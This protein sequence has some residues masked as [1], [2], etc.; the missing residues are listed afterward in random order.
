MNAAASVLT[1][2]GNDT[3]ENESNARAP[4]FC[5]PPTSAANT[6]SSIFSSTSANSSLSSHS[7]S[8]LPFVSARPRWMAVCASESRY[9]RWRAWVQA[10]HTRVPAFSPPASYFFR[11]YPR[12]LVAGPCS[13]HRREVPH[14]RHLGSNPSSPPPSLGPSPARSR[15]SHIFR[16]TWGL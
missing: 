16:G 11:S 14:R 12:S 5:V 2:A 15:S 9:Q 3:H 8:S 10:G 7:S 4:G 1:T 13:E 6:P